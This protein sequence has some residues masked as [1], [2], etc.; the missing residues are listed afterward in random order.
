MAKKTFN[1]EDKN[2]NLHGAAALFAP[3]SQEG[4]QQKEETREPEY[5]EDE[6][7]TGYQLRLQKGWL[8]QLKIMSANT[9]TSVKDLILNAVAEKYK[10]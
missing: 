7:I 8:K 6:E 9:D 1:L 3:S 10:L 4:K 2:K 5:N